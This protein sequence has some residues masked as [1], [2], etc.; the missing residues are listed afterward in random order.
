MGVKPWLLHLKSKNC[1]KWG[2]RSQ[3]VISA[4]A[5]EWLLSSKDRSEFHRSCTTNTIPKIN[6]ARFT[7]CLRSL[8]NHLGV[9]SWRAVNI[10]A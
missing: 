9:W 6:A 1:Q 7:K 3:C 10:L 4:D 2:V 5:L 8:A